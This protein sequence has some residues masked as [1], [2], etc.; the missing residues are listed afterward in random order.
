MGVAELERR[1]ASH[2]R[3][4]AP[5]RTAI[6]CQKQLFRAHNPPGVGAEEVHRG[7]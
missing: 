5:K 2:R 1:F 4:V 3:D 7:D 6:A